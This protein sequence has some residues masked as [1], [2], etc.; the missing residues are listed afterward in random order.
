MQAQG[1]RKTLV[2]EVVSNKMVKT[3]SVRVDR[4]MK[5][6][7]FK[8][9]VRRSSTFM[10]HDENSLCQ[11]GDRVKIIESRPLSRHKRW[12]VMAILERAESQETRRNP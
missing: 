3:V 8:R 5:H 2:G 4:L 10:A 9:Y 6:P 11:P 1:R 12:R 7:K